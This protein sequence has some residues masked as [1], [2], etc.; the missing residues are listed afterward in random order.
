MEGS[1]PICCALREVEE[2]V[3]VH[4]G[5]DGSPGRAE[6]SRIFW[7]QWDDP[8]GSGIEWISRHCAIA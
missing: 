6:G 5:V 3:Y 8:L 2:M 1:V 4:S 7:A